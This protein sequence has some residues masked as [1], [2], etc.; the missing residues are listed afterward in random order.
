M[1]LTKAQIIASDDLPKE[2]VNVPEWG[3]EVYVRT[4]TAKERDDYEAGF[5][6]Q[7]GGTVKSIDLANV[8]ARLVAM[9][10][11]DES[12][13]RMFNDM[14]VFDL[15][16][17]SAVALSRVYEVAKRLSGISQTDEAEMTKNSV[18]GESG[19]SPSA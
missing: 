3:G 2:L 15:G 8:R 7:Q 10:L 6:V 14:E 9:T 1:L 17:K 13:K 19:D 5:V 11:V 16:R 12:G 4:L 18:A